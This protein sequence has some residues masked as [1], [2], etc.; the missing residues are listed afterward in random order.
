MNN[1]SRTFNSKKNLM[2]GMISMI[3]KTIISFIS[4]TI[5]IKY[6][7]T[8]YLGINGLF[9]NILSLLSISEFGLTSVAIYS[10][11]KPIANN[12]E[13][14]IKQLINYYEKIYRIVFVI[15]FFGGLLL[16]PFLKFIINSNI[17]I[18][19]IIIFYALYLFSSSISYL[20][21]SK[22]ILIDADQ[23]LYIK[24]KAGTIFQA[25]QKITQIVL[26]IF[27]HNY[28]LYLITEC[29]SSVLLNV[30]LV[31]KANKI[32][33]FLKDK[34]ESVELTKQEKKNLFQKQKDTFIYRLSVTLV[35]STDNIYISKLINTAAVGLYSN[36]SMIISLLST[37]IKTIISSVK[38]SVGNLNAKSTDIKKLDVFYK[39]LFI[40]QWIV[41]FICVC[42][43]ILFNDFIIIWIGKEYVFPSLTVIIIVLYFYL[44]NIINP[45]WVYCETLGLFKEIKK[46]MIY[47]AILNII[48]SFVFGKTMGLSGIILASIASKLMTEVW[49]EPIILLKNQFKTSVKKYYTYQLGYIS[50]FA[51]TFSLIYFITKN[52][53]VNSLIMFIVKGIIITVLFN[54]IYLIVFY[55]SDNFKFV[56]NRLHNVKK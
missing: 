33:P 48:F 30:Y 24:N 46:V 7:S 23:R 35:V 41:S 37:F 19:E 32:Y 16:I 18:N 27:T 49:Y 36:Y 40:M 28:Y 17:D 4:R 45:V 42:L 38:S 11:Y 1:K 15:F 51:I 29:L 9:S 8:D 2:F 53:I 14:K 31:R 6:L 26:L 55:N 5:F 39:L 43:I 12:D 44:S 3:A 34:S 22:Q 47:N 20:A 56:V 50:L 54:L 10:L 21:A 25:I 52:I 13:K